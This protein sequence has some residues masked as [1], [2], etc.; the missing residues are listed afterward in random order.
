MKTLFN[1]TMTAGWSRLA[2]LLSGAL[3]VFAYAPFQQSWMVIPILVLLLWLGRDSSPRRAWQLGYLFGI[4]WFSAGLSW[5][6]VSID[7]FGGLPVVATI[8]VL[9]V[10]FAYLSLFPALALWAWRSATAR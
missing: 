8:A 3:L 6:Y 10:L 4:G 5:I 9:A 7:T 1:T 2:A